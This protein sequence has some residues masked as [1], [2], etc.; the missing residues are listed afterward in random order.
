MIKN[1]DCSFKEFFDILKDALNNGQDVKKSDEPFLLKCGFIV[2]GSD[3][4]LIKL[5]ELKY[6]Q[7]D[8]ID[9]SLYMDLQE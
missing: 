6:A 3:R 7:R 1:E 2:D 4:Y 9:T 5:K 8:G